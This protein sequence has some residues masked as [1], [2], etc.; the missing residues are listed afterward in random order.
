M[1]WANQMV[2]A[3]DQNGL[4]LL[5]NLNCFLASREVPYL[6]KKMNWWTTLFGDWW[7]A[8]H[9]ISLSD[10]RRKLV[11]T[12]NIEAI[13]PVSLKLCLKILCEIRLKKR[14]CFFF[15]NFFLLYCFP[16]TQR[17][18]RS[19]SISLTNFN[20]QFH[21]FQFLIFKFHQFPIS[22]KS[23]NFYIN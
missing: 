3:W 18:H 16:L 15:F 10:L 17:G 1:K 4:F 9:V 20:F 21:H 11:F 19:H 22:K 5:S 12:E 7:R 6:V 8:G 14:T 23:R 2:T 13:S